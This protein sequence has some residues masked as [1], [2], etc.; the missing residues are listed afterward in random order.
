MSL[1]FSQ[2]PTFYLVRT[3]LT[4]SIRGSVPPTD[5]ISQEWADIAG[6][7]MRHQIVTRPLG[8]GQHTV[9]MLEHIHRIF[10]LNGLNFLLGCSSPAPSSSDQNPDKVSVNFVEM[11]PL[12]LASPPRFSH[13]LISSYFRTKSIAPQVWFPPEARY[14]WNNEAAKLSRRIGCFSTSA[15]VHSDGYISGAYI[16]YYYSAATFCQEVAAYLLA[17]CGVPHSDILARYRHNYDDIYDFKFME[18]QFYSMPKSLSGTAL[19]L[20]NRSPELK[21]F[22][23]SRRASS[24]GDLLFG[25][26]PPGSNPFRDRDQI[27]RILAVH[28]ILANRI[29]DATERAAVDIVPNLETAL[30]WATVDPEAA[31]LVAERFLRCAIDPE[32]L[33]VELVAAIEG[34]HPN[35]KPE[36]AAEASSSLLSLGFDDLFD[37]LDFE[38]LSE[39]FSRETS[40]M[41]G[42]Q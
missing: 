11:K 30:R 15:C 40:T 37:G 3:E 32:T 16:H 29:P 34:L 14:G 25:S 17:K 31:I 12:Y 6:D 2:L 23:I 4:L 9:S 1:K 28:Q 33:R 13:G 19:Y 7:N 42:G 41:G 35:A 24:V 38:R 21:R 27:Y 8:D 10:Q 18:A 22:A 20:L 36:F 39:E 26:R 5:D